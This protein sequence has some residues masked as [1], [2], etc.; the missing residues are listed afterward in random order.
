MVELTASTMRGYVSAVKGWHSPLGPPVA[1]PTPLEAFL[2]RFSKGHKRKIF[3]FNVHIARAIWLENE[4]LQLREGYHR[5]GGFGHGD[6]TL[7]AG[8]VQEI[9]LGNIGSYLG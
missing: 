5:D 4:G 7:N 9:K 3:Q 2:S 6:E 1:T 8:V